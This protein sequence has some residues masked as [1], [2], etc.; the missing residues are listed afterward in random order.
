MVCR[1]TGFGG[2]RISTPL[3]RATSQRR[4]SGLRRMD[5]QDQ[6]HHRPHLHQPHGPIEKEVVKP[7]ELTRGQ[8]IYAYI[9]SRSLVDDMLTSGWA[10]RLGTA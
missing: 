6:D 9:L 2:V 10:H 3:R 7:K 4:A 5:I 8:F 1:L